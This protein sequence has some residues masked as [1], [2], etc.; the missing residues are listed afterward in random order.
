MRGSRKKKILQNIR[1]Q[2]LKER[3]SKFIKVSIQII[4]GAKQPFEK[5]ET[6][7]KS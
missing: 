2:S 7:G 1:V 3:E 6:S 5:Q 4:S